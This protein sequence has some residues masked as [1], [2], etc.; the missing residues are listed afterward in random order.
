MM[1]N[2]YLRVALAT[3]VCFIA[4][5][6]SA[7]QIVYTDITD[8]AGIALTPELVES[9]AWGDYD[10]DNDGDLDLVVTADAGQPTRL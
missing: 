8:Q 5:G 6:T 2:H 10:N 4:V 3:A 1:I 9:L 7:A